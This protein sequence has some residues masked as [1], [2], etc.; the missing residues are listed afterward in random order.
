MSDYSQPDFYRFSEDSLR[1]V[2]F[3]AATYESGVNRIAD[4][5]AGCGIIGIE[6]SR[7]LWPRE[8]F[9]LEAQEE[10]RPHL[11]ANLEGFL[12]D[13]VRSE[14][15]VEKF[16]ESRW[17]SMGF[18]LVLCN[19]PFYLPGAGEISRDPRRHTCRSFHL[20][21]WGILLRLLKRNLTANGE[22]VFVLP[23]EKKLLEKV[24]FEIRAQKLSARRVTEDHLTFLRVGLNED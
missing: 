24:E 21:D 13:G 7:R 9:L 8:L 18:D 15:F 17:N 12:P 22:G 11:E 10:F 14:I 5:G 16:S 4:F 2:D 3:V 19:P 23:S 6:A 1:L 20:D